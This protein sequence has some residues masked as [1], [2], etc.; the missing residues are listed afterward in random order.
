MIFH[1]IVKVLLLIGLFPRMYSDFQ[2]MMEGIAEALLTNGQLDQGL[3][4]LRVSDKNP[5]QAFVRVGK[6]LF[7]QSHVVFAH[8]AFKH[9]LYS[10]GLARVGRHY[11]RKG[12]FIVGTK[13]LRLAGIEPTDTE[14]I[15]CAWQLLEL[16][17]PR[18]AKK[19]YDAV[20][21]LHLPKE[22]FLEYGRYYF[23][24]G[25]VDAGIDALLIASEDALLGG[26]GLRHLEEGHVYQATIIFHALKVTPPVEAL[27]ASADRLLQEGSVYEAIRAYAAARS[28]GWQPCGTR[29]IKLTTPRPRRH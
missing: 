8:H 24:H 3:K 21:T 29:L 18:E 12:N 6:R 26:Y 22:Q 15:H 28:A 11:L 25:W 23:A 16:R 14:L 20:E 10:E 27:V 19:V 5:P 7:N 2:D 17:Q 9:A 1:M 4:L 13:A